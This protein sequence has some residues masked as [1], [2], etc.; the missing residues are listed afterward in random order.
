MRDFYLNWKECEGKEERM[1]CLEDSQDN[2]IS[3]IL[4]G[5]KKNKHYDENKSR[6]FKIMGDEKFYKTCKKMT[7]KSTPCELNP[8]FSAV[9]LSF[10]EEAS[11][12]ID[13]ELVND[14]MALAKKCLKKR[15]EALQKKVDLP[16]SLI[17]VTLGSMPDVELVNNNKIMGKFISKALNR[18]YS[19]SANMS[20]EDV[21][22][23]STQELKVLMK[24]VFG[25]DSFPRVL[26]TLALESGNVEKFNDNTK[27]LYSKFTQ[28][29]LD[30]L[31]DCSKD[32]LRDFFEVYIGQRKRA[33]NDYKRRVD[34]TLLEGDKYDKVKSVI[35]KLEEDE[36]EFIK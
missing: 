26:I 3:F 23:I 33:Y 5:S 16:E 8:A 20:K 21:E 13:E 28:L 2:I 4:F 15:M 17:F 11:N 24:K 35:D 1:Y 22:K 29:L 12:E 18:M 14:Y 27:L 34:F 30:E 6:L 9:I 25:K 32:D 36:I 19:Y 31:A 10:L 7:K